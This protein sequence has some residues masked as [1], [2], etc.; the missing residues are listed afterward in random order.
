MECES[1]N[2]KERF[3]RANE[4]G[5]LSDDAYK[6]ILNT[7]QYVLMFRQHHQLEALK[8]GGQPNS[9]INPDT[10]GSF[11]RGNLKDAFLII[12]GLQDAAKVRFGG[13]I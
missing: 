5:I 1:A 6:N 9:H 7:Y 8:Q 10:F 3:T 4:Q 11:E 12:S 2:T 13:R